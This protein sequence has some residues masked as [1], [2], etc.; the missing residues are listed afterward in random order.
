MNVR[1]PFFFTLETG[2]GWE[3]L[4]TILPPGPASFIRQQKQLINQGTP[5]L[6]W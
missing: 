3:L 2:N 4:C 6:I 5:T 1:Q